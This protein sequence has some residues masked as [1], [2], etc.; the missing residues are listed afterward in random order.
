[1]RKIAF[2]FAVICCAAFLLAGCQN[3]ADRS[4]AD[5]SVQSDATGSK[6]R[7]KTVLDIKTLSNSATGKSTNLITIRP[8]EDWTQADLHELEIISEKNKVKIYGIWATETSKDGTDQTV[9][10]SQADVKTNAQQWNNVREFLESEE[11]SGA[12]LT[13]IMLYASDIACTNIQKLFED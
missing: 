9:K 11:H 13:K 5:S 4:L 10:L 8:G 7:E 6:Q 1:M 2:F 12:R 3:G